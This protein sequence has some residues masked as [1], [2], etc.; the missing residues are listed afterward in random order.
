MLIS[1]RQ[2]KAARALLEWKQS[3]L[4]SSAGVSLTAVN[5]LE[6]QIGSARTDTVRAIQLALEQAGVEFLP[7][8]GVKL[9]GERLEVYK[10]EGLEFVEK[11]NDDMFSVL[12]GPEDEVVMWGIDE[13]RFD[14]FDA[15][16]PDAYQQAG[17]QRGFR[18][19]IIVAEG[20]DYFIS[21]PSCYRWVPP[22]MFG[23]LPVMVYGDRVAI[24]FWN[25][26]QRCLIIRNQTLADS[27]R[28]QFELLW[29]VAK[30][31]PHV[32]SRRYKERVRPAKAK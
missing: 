2:I 16:S 7:D 18:E 10:Y 5:N 17:I 26:P 22:E 27:F 9:R 23:T 24:M 21:A 19:R 13:R 31:H 30:V 32:T 20:D 1:H 14:E 28:A 6:R 8:D 12:L 15:S 11:L 4:A 3:N 29:S 25:K